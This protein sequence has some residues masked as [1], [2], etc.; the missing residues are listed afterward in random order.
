MR[1]TLAAVVLATGAIAGDA[2][3][4]DYTTQ[5]V[6]VTDC[7]PEVPDCPAHQKTTAVSSTV[8]P[9]TTSTVYSTQV[10]TITSCPPEI[11]KCPA[12]STVYSTEIIAVSTTVCPVGPPAV[13]THYGNA[14]VPAHGCNGPECPPKPTTVVVCNGPGC[15]GK[16]TDKVP[17]GPGSTVVPPPAVE[18]PKVPSCKTT[19]VTAITKSYTTV[20]TTVEYSTIEVACPTGGNGVPTGVIPPPVKTGEVCHGPECPAVPTK[21]AEGCKG[22]ECPAV[23]SKPVDNGCKGGNCT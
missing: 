6:T 11:V 10:H 21:P 8:L 15:P 2:L 14:T 7:P 19:S 12:H 9:L 4:T 17:H 1:F 3:S 16:E 23:P 18:T 5:L 22:P 13:P 20:L